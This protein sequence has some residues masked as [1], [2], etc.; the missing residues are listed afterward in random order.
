KG[1]VVVS[2]NVEEGMRVE[3]GGNIRVSGLVSGA[4]IQAAGSIL[5]RGNILASVVVAGG[6]PAFL[7]GLLPQIQ[8]LVEGLEEMIIVIGQLLGHMRLKQGHLKW[9]IGP[10]LKSLLEGKFNYLL[11]AINTLKEQCGTV[12]PELFGESLEEFLRE[13]ERILGHSTLAI[14]TLYEVETLA[15]KA[16][17]LMQFLSVSP[18]PASDLI[19]SSILNSTL[20]ATGDVKI[21]GSGCYN[22]RIKAGKKV[23]VTGVFRGGEIEAGG[24]VYIGEIGSPGGCATRV[25]T[26]T[27]AV[28]TVEFAFENASLLIGSQLYRFDRDE[29]SVRVWLD[30]EG[31]L[32]FKG[33]PA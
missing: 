3:A 21:V 24:D 14:Q 12:S 17:E 8:T 20:I 5:I 26:A 6:I 23:T 1:D 28:I 32:Q 10:L 13:A 9:G 31:K 22:S 19:G 4:E 2:N 25:I 30:K 16:K 29:K 27:E 11:S 33:I 18:T 15:K 7:Q